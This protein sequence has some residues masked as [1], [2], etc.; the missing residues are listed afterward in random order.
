VRGRFFVIDGPDGGGKTTQ[1]AALADHLRERG[2]RVTTLREPGA[3]TA[4][5]SIREI[6]L[7][8]DTDLT[9]T[10]E[11][12][13]YQA[14][15]AQLVE[16]V[17]RPALDA[18]TSILL[19]RFWYSTAAY[20]AYGLGLDPELV[21]VVSRVATGGLEPDHLFLLDIDP[22]V[23]LARIRGEH[24]RIEGRPLEYH[25]R[26]R[27]GF[28]AEA[29]RLGD[30]ATILDAARPAAEVSAAIRA[31]VDRLGSA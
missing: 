7:D 22:E 27:D 9:A 3:T 20:Q 18:G 4:G 13:L 28:L 2:E 17:L 24:D 1:V 26:V 8:P 6:L 10:A 19:D 31:V 25:R 21:R 11:M 30:R 12:L 29:R 14:A 15:R 16:A 23:G 5:E